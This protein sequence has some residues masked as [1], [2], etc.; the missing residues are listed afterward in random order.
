VSQFT[1]SDAPA[2]LFGPDD[3]QFDATLRGH[4]MAYT[5]RPGEKA[6]FRWDNIGKYCAENAQRAHRPKYFGNSKF[7]FKP[8]L[9]LEAIRQE[10]A[11]VEGISVGTASEQG[12]KLA[13][14]SV[15][16]HLDY[17]IQI[18]Y[19]ACGGTVR[20]TFF[21]LWPEDRF[22]LAISLDGKSWKELWE[23]QGRGAHDAEVALDP[24]LDVHNKPAKYEYFVRVRLGSSGGKQ[25]ANLGSLE[26]E[27]DVLAAPASL[28]RLTRGANRVVYRDETDGDHR[29]RIT[30][31]W[32][33][34]GAVR[35]LARI[36]VPEYPKPGARMRD[37]VVTFA[38]PGVEE[39]DRYHLQV[40]R[41]PDFKYPYRPCLDVIIPTT[42]WTVPYTGIFSPDTTYYWRLRCRDHWGVWGDWSDAWTFTWHG[43]RVPV[44]LRFEAEGQAITLHWAP[45][46][47][48]ERPVRYRVYG[49]DER[50]FSVRNGEHQVPGRGTV[51]GNLLDE[52]TDTSMVVVSPEATAA[53]ANKVFY[54]VVAID[55][56][57]TASG[58]SD[59]VELPHP[60]VYARPITEARVGQE[61]R[62]EVK[63]LRSLGDYQCKQDPTVNKKQYAYRFWDIDENTDKITQGPSWLQLDE[64]TGVLAG[65]P[66]AGDAGTTTVK[67]KVTNQFG[68][69]AEQEFEITVQ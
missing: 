31:E 61:Y 44:N 30:H 22:S 47:R 40:S 38:W 28:P 13:G 23:S 58:C 68:G 11:T 49:S 54:R 37:S 59:Y 5:L 6:I 12:G 62:Y 43:P 36:E 55:T 10:A 4:E 20:G 33:E 24:A 14:Q 34:T 45:N 50:G 18:P 52:T 16:S 63:S 27:T 2:A 1:S 48:G 69:R 65:T 46:P 66:G 35:P 26:I 15:E 67:L 29:L 56:A 39:A 19:P 25:G 51:P 53:G 42:T 21:G 8:R 57:G 32:K 17:T 41:R 9:T 7:I 64:E 3:R 60:F